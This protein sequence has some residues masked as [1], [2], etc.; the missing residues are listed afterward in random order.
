MI[1]IELRTFT[2][3]EYHT[4]FRQY[5]PDPM[6]DLSP[7]HYNRE[8]ISR[9]YIYN[10]GGY[11]DHYV[12]LGIFLDQEPIGSFQLKR[13]DPDSGQCE[14]G[15]ILRDDSVK[16]RGIGT[17]AIKA[18]AVAADMTAEIARDQYRMNTIIGDTMGRNK[19]M[20]HIFEKLGFSLTEIVPGAFELPDGSK[21]DRW[22]YRKKLT[23]EDD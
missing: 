14:F 3:D 4:F 15:I 22:V 1:P 21:E 6:M 13:M 18:G 9:S 11:R 2:E 16:N 12:H 8:Q 23:E 17:A 10:H 20:I 5:K 19:R 7:F